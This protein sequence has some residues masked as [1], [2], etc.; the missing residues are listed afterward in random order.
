MARATT[1]R[2]ILQP[3][4]AVRAG[5]ARRTFGPREPCLETPDRDTGG[6]GGRRLVLMLSRRDLGV[7]TA[8]R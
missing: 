4:G 3:H 2:P 8:L 6:D 5:P 7:T 1:P